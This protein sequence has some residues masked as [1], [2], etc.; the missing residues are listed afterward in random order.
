MLIRALLFLLCA[1]AAAIV[2]FGWGHEMIVVLD[3]VVPT[4]AQGLCVLFGFC[5]LVCLWRGRSWEP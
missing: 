1:I 3:A 2:G 4:I 5:F